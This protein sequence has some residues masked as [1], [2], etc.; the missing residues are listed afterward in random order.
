MIVARLEGTDFEL[1]CDTP[2]GPLQVFFPAQWPGDPLPIF[3]LYLTRV[4]SNGEK[5]GSFVA[6]QR[7][8]Q[9][10]GTG[11]AVGQ[12]GSKGQPDAAGALEIGYGMN[13]SAWGQG[14]ATEAVRA[15]VAWLHAR[16]DVQTV[17]A[18]TALH[19]RAS[20]RV[21]EKLGFVRT[22]TGWDE[23]DGELTQWAYQP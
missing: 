15:L 13:P 12:L 6:V 5:P 10:P 20:E 1:T 16:P 21:L 18:Q 23:E 3:P 2:Q 9:R 14:L 22:G 4:D 19:N 17:T 7:D 11:R 8:P